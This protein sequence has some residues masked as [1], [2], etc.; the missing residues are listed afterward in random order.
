M[1]S[2]PDRCE[3]PTRT[4]DGAGLVCIVTMRGTHARLRS[5]S[6]RGG[7]G[8]TSPSSRRLDHR[9]P[10][11]HRRTTRRLV[12]PAQRHDRRLGPTSTPG[13]PARPPRSW[14]RRTRAWP[15]RRVARS[16]SAC[17]PAWRVRRGSRER[18]R[19]PRRRAGT[20]AHVRGPDRRARVEARRASTD[21]SPTPPRLLEVDRARAAQPGRE[22]FVRHPVV[23]EERASNEVVHVSDF[24]PQL[25]CVSER[26]PHRLDEPDIVRSDA[27]R[28]TEQVH[29]RDG[30]VD[31][32][33]RRHHDHTHSR[34][35]RSPCPHRTCPR[36][37]AE[38][39][40]TSSAVV[41]RHVIPMS[42]VAI[43]WKTASPQPAA[44]R[45]RGFTM[46]V[47][48]FDLIQQLCASQYLVRSL[49][50]VAELGVADAVGEGGRSV[51]EIAEQVGADADA[52]K[53]VLRLLESREA[54]SSLTATSSNTAR[55][56]S[57]CDPIIRP[58][59]RRSPGCSPSRCSGGRRRS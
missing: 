8:G 25:P 35:H 32:P 50:V 23:A 29:V 34:S 2:S 21:R 24:A 54:S 19:L 4:N 15:Q 7:G 28:L 52:L 27:N 49:H 38:Q 22:R 5:A 58:R 40:T 59:S 11:G 10:S 39:R 45:D 1:P 53:R 41:E 56:R 31:H 33:Q 6:R 44:W 51:E 9:R 47:Q 3:S 16:G 14:H 36:N 55:R 42:G 18:R 12:V 13:T 46:D 43:T 37:D 20:G 48:G 17:L 26:R 30:P 57:S